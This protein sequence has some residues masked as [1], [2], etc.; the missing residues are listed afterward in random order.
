MTLHY[1]Q[2]LTLTAALLDDL[3]SEVADNRSGGDDEKPPG[4]IEPANFDLFAAFTATQRVALIFDSVP[5]IQ[6]LFN[7]AVISYK[8]SCNLKCLLG[9]VRP[10]KTLTLDTKTNLILLIRCEESPQ[11]LK[12]TGRERRES[13]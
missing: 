7:M 12:R 11:S 10:I 9:K 8:K 13:K 3:T 1:S 5:F 2:A 6:L 4:K